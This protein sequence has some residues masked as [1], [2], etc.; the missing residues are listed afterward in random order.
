[1]NQ[2]TTNTLLLIAS[3]GLAIAGIIFLCVEIF[4]ETKSNWELCSAIVCVLLSSLF[5]VIRVSFNR[6]EK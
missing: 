4:G 6:K 1:M 5:N 3:A 2:K